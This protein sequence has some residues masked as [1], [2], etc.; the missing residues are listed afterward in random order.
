[1]DIALLIAQKSQKDPREY[2]PFLRNLNEM[3]VEMSRFTID[4]FLKR[5][6]KA[7]EHL[8]RCA[9]SKS[10][11]DVVLYVKKHGLYRDAMSLCKENREQYDV[12]PP[13]SH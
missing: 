2:L 13:G 8:S 4:D 10:F 5:Y 12:L 6:A 7:L 11:E 1:M 3:D 9:S